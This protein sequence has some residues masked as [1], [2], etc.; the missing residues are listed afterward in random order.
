[1]T[2]ATPLLGEGTWLFLLPCS[3]EEESGEMQMERVEQ[4]AEEGRGDSRPNSVSV[5]LHSPVL[6]HSGGAGSVPGWRALLLIT[7]ARS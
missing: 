4:E 5:A 1:M 6:L 3:P 2:W 7:T